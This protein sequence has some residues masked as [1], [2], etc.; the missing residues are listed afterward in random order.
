M[1]L[2]KFLESICEH[3]VLELIISVYVASPEKQRRVN[4]SL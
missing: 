4:G 1:T 2:L 3:A